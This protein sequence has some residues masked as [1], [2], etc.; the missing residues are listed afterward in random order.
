MIIFIVTFDFYKDGLD[1]E[2]LNLCR[3]TE[4]FIGYK[5]ILN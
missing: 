5:T 1:E 3:K 2:D 4:I